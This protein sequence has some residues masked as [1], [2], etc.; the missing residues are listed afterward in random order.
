MFEKITKGKANT[1]ECDIYMDDNN[2]LCYCAESRNEA[3]QN[4]EFI[5]YCFNLQYRYDIS[6]LKET[7]ETLESV[8]ELIGNFRLKQEVPTQEVWER[9]ESVLFKVKSNN[10]GMCS[11]R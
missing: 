6:Q 2:M 3:K 9:I 1:V 11:S 7:I 10:H 8:K 4:V 5:A